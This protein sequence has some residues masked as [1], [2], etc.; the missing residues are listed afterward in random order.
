MI[1][2]CCC[3]SCMGQGWTGRRALVSRYVSGR[4]L[5]MF[6]CKQSRCLIELVCL[7]LHFFPGSDF[8]TASVKIG[9]SMQARSTKAGGRCL[10]KASDAK[11][12]PAGPDKQM[13]A[14]TSSFEKGPSHDWQAAEA[15][16]QRAA[17]CC[18]A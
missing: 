12:Q 6:K 16:G 4:L 10:K 13:T 15:S 14:M 8:S 1:F 7:Q 2:P 3:Q 18:D 9:W 5:D 17:I 11:Q